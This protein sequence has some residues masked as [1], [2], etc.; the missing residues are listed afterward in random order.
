MPYT[1]SPKAASNKEGNLKIMLQIAKTRQESLFSLLLFNIYSSL[2]GQEIKLNLRMTNSY[3]FKVRFC[4][5]LD[6]THF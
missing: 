2:A 3:S 1:I 5:R 6:D 4:V